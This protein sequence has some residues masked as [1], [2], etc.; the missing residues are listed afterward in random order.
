MEEAGNSGLKRFDQ[1]IKIREA[2]IMKRIREAYKF[3]TELTCILIN[4]KIIERV[5]NMQKNCESFLL[6]N[7]HIQMLR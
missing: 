1:N 4:A 5:Q 2:K 6:I 7:K 3:Q